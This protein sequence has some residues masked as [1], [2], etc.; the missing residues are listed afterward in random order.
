VAVSDP[1]REQHSN[2]QIATWS[3]SQG[4]LELPTI[5]RD[6]FKLPPALKGKL[7]EASSYFVAAEGDRGL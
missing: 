7:T 3:R 2:L 5:R 4:F 1:N 6:H